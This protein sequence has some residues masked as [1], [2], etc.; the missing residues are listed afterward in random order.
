MIGFLIAVLAGFLTPYAEA[1]IGKPIAGLL[2]EH[3]RLEIGELR[4]VTF[5]TMMLLAGVAS[6]LFES[7]S[8]FWVILGGSIGYF[9]TRA[10]AALQAAMEKRQ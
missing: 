9:L 6:A 10:T 8:T 5:M 1:P 7:G 4:L 2:E 3:L